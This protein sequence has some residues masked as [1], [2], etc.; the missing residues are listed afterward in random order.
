[1]GRDVARQNRLASDTTDYGRVPV[2]T[3]ELPWA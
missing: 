1:M 3:S 2:R